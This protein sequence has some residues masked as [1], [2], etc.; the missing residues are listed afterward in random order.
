MNET[1]TN[2]IQQKIQDI[3]SDPLGLAL[4]FIY[5]IGV[6][7][8]IYALM[9]VTHAAVEKDKKPLIPA[10]KSGLLSLLFLLPSPLYEHFFK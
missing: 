7:I 2:S 8:L 4:K 9:N 6:L 5:V 3:L 1:I 10:L